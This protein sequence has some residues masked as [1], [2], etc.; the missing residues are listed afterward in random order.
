M[1][2]FDREKSMEIMKKRTDRIRLDLQ[3]DVLEKD[4]EIE[5][6]LT[7]IR[8]IT[9]DKEEFATQLSRIS[10][11]NAKLNDILA[12]KIAEIDH[13]EEEKEN[14]LQI[15]QQLAQI[16][17]PNLN[18]RSQSANKINSNN[19]NSINNI[20][21]SN[22]A[23]ERGFEIPVMI[24]EDTTEEPLVITEESIEEDRETDSSDTILTEDPGQD[25]VRIARASLL[26][27]LEKTMTNIWPEGVDAED[28]EYSLLEAVRKERQ[29]SGLNTR[30]EADLEHELVVEEIMRS[31]R[32]SKSPASIED[33]SLVQIWEDGV[34]DEMETSLLEAVRKERQDSG[35]NARLEADLEHEL[36]VEEITRSE[37][38]SKSPASIEDSSLVQIWEDGVEDEMETSLIEAVRKERHSSGLN[39]RL[40]AD[41]IQ[42]WEDGIGD[43]METSLLEAVR[44]E[45]HSS[46]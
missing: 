42:I 45:R 36:V 46:G 14:L 2:P 25:S 5:S 18:F 35:L 21:I 12:E 40:E 4:K 6:Y 11:E 33:S 3:N 7:T 38:G 26:E 15:V 28:M 8:R 31:E 34:E 13:F 29:D 37:R 27:D 39:A 32:G 16:G 22:D 19:D 24:K 9:N 23:Q 41:Q 1:T 10:Q 30:L 43:A 17:N 20:N 44:K